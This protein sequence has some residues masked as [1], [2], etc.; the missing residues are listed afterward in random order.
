MKGTVGII[1]PKRMDY[2]RVVG[3]LKGIKQQLDD[4]YKKE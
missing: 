2:D 3:V 4:L 1:G